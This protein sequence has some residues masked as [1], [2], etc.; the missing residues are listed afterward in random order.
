ME[1]I[2]WTDRMRNEEVLQLVK[3]ERYVIHA[4]QRRKASST[5]HILRRRGLLYHMSDGKIDGRIEVTGRRGRRRMWLL[6]DLNETKGHCKLKEETLDRP[7][8]RTCFGR[9]YGPVVRQATE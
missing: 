5:G 2:S 7:L 9:G 3:E 1:Y 4:V 8:W 6:Y